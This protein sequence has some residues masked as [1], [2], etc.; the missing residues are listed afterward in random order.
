MLILNVKFQ[1]KDEAKKLGAKWNPDLKKW[2]VS[3]ASKYFRFR[4]WFN[5]KTANIICE[6]LYLIET[7]SYCWKCHKENSIVCLA[8]DKFYTETFNTQSALNTRLTLFYF[9]VYYPDFLKFL[10]ENNNYTYNY[11][12]QFD[13]AFHHENNGYYVSNR[14]YICHS[15]QGDYFF[16]Q[17]N[18]PRRGFYQCITSPD[19]NL[20]MHKLI[21]LPS[22]VELDCSMHS[23]DLYAHMVTGIENLASIDVDKFILRD[24]SKDEIDITKYL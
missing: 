2:Y 4:K 17:I 7:K 16:H 22:A 23:D 18:R 3:D 13:T 9:L 11:S 6:D 8:S 24:A 15:L 20:K 19:K 1:E 10:F 5:I 12:N 21:N 14:C